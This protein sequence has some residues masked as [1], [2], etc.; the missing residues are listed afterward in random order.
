[1]GTERRATSTGTPGDQAGTIVALLKGALAQQRDDL[2]RAVDGQVLQ[3]AC[4]SLQDLQEIHRATPSEALRLAI[5]N[6]TTAIEALRKL[7]DDQEAVDAG[8]E[9]R[10]LRVVREALAG[11]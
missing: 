6:L 8:L 1:M 11:G 10:A 3:Y 2:T 7:V 5:A 9:V 4:L